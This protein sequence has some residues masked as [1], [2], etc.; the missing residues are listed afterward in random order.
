MVAKTQFAITG[1]D[2]RYFLNGALF[3]LRHD[4]MTLVATDGHR[5]ALVTAPREG[6]PKAEE[7][8]TI[9]PKKT[10]IELGRLLADGDGDDPVRARREPHL[11]PRSTGACSCRG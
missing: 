1:E 9:L 4:A 10:L 7:T 11:L 2:T 6:D 3:V 8:R 5:L